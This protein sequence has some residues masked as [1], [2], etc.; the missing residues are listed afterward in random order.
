M[1]IISGNKKGRKIVNPK[2][3]FRPTQSKVREAF[4]NIV[5]AEEADALSTTAFLMGT[6]FFTNEA[7]KY[8]EAYIVTPEG[9]L[10]I[11]TNESF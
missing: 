2:R 10:Y 6:N 8:K 5:N 1:Y 4:F 7:F 9:E 11:V 3:D